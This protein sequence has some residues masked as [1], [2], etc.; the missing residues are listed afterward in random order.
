[1]TQAFGTSGIFTIIL[2]AEPGINAVHALRALLK[3]ALR[4]HGLRAL[5]CIEQTTPQQHPAVIRRRRSDATQARREGTKEMDMSKYAGS[6]FVSLDDVVNGPIR[7][8][9]VH[10]ELG[11]FDKPVVTFSNGCRFSLNV[12]NAQALIKA[13][14]KESDDW[15]GEQLELYAGE[16]KYRG[17]VRPSVLAR[18]L[19]QRKPGPKTEPKGSGDPND[20]IPF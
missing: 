8:E 6:A 18:P 1:M 16:L 5:S 14:G 17:E 12:T 10:V 3:S 9:I 15:I 19:G 11:S 4:V 2:R 20:E 7:G 13:F